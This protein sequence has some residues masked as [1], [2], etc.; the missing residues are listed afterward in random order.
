MLSMLQ[1]SREAERVLR[2]CGE[3]EAT[4][5]VVPT[6]NK[7]LKRIALVSKDPRRSKNQL[8]GCCLDWLSLA[9]SHHFLPLS[10][11]P[12][13]FSFKALLGSPRP[14]LGALTLN[15]AISVSPAAITQV[16]P[17]FTFQKLCHVN[18]TM[19]KMKLPAQKS[20]GDKTFPNHGRV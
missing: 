20:L 8:R 9:K 6:C 18:A 13:L 16:H 15:L 5:G 3:S 1:C 4:V 7:P 17:M 14:S 2:T 19:I 12:S 10:L 11:L